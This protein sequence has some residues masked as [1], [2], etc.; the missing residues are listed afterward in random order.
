MKSETQKLYSPEILNKII[1][2]KS[3][4]ED[5]FKRIEMDKIN[6]IMILDKKKT[7]IL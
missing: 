3:K 2:M 1:E 6:K 5:I 4:T 7:S